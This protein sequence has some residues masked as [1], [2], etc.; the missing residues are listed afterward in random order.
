MNTV[1]FL[2]ALRE[3]TLAM[4]RRGAV[5]WLSVTACAVLAAAA[6]GQDSEQP[7]AA[8]K[9]E[10]QETAEAAAAEAAAFEAQL[11]QAGATI[12]AINV[13]VDNVFDPSNPKEDKPIYRWANKVH[14]PTHDSAIESALL[15]G[16]G[17]RYTARALSESARTLRGRGYIADVK[18]TPRD[19]DP[20]ANTVAVD[21]R[22]RGQTQ[23]VS[24]SSRVEQCP[25]YPEIH[26]AAVARRISGRR[27][28]ETEEPSREREARGGI[29][30]VRP[31]PSF[32]PHSVPQSLQHLRVRSALEARDDRACD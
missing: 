12:R 14:F 19:Y 31:V 11:A 16:V 17:D 2:R 18:I 21:V 9:T 26:C 6:Q 30:W 5:G 15:F 23:A 27:D 20:G 25:L 10:G 3:C 13:T 8:D 28:D 4:G 22:V 29:D 7:A 1:E 24:V 32:A